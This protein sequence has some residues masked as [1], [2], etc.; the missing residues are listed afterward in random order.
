MAVVLFLQ[1]LLVALKGQ[2]W[3]WEEW[4]WDDSG[5]NMTT[6]RSR[7]RGRED[8]DS[9]I[10]SGGGRRCGSVPRAATLASV[11]GYAGADTLITVGLNI[12][13]SLVTLEG[14][15]HSCSAHHG[16]V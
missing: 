11:W 12:T 2:R 4:R 9:H 10:S 7:Q 13:G 14:S 16:P 3:G 6:A 15:T 1:E 5:E 8:S